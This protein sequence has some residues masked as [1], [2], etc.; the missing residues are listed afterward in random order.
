M[1]L[2]WP[3]NERKPFI[4]LQTLLKVS[5]KNRSNGIVELTVDQALET[6][7]KKQNICIVKAA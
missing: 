1:K 6:G 2:T 4:F 7:Y 5:N 3:V